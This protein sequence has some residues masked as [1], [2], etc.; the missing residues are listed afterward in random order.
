MNRGRIIW[1][2]EVVMLGIVLRDFFWGRG[3]C[4]E[5]DVEGGSWRWEGGWAIRSGFAGWSY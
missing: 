2:K 4:G 5:V 3:P 1:R